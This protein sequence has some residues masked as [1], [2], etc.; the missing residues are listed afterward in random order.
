MTL[1]LA[2]VLGA[3][4]EFRSHIKI[5]TIVS[6]KTDFLIVMTNHAIVYIT[7]CFLLVTILYI[8]SGALRTTSSV[9]GKPR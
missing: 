3:C 2:L 5:V 6:D 8:V 4:C 7:I 1:G 9:R